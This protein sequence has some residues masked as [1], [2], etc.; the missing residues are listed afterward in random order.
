[1]HISV[2]KDAAFRSSLRLK[3]GAET[4]ATKEAIKGM[5]TSPRGEESVRFLRAVSLH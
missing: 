2:I 4:I 1:M 5:K 3:D